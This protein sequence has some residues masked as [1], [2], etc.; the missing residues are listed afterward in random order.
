MKYIVDRYRPDI[1]VVMV[2]END[3]QHLRTSSGDIETEIGTPEFPP[4]YE[5]RVEH[6][7]KIATSAGGHVVWVSMPIIRDEERWPLHERQNAIYEAV[8]DRL[9]NV[10]YVD[11]F[12]RF[13]KDGRYT[14]Y[15]D[16]GKVIQIREDDGLH[17]TADGYTLIMR[18]VAEVAA[19]EFGLDPKTFEG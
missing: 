6:F 5:E 1:T 8:A 7:A 10:A 11:T 19:E 18:L 14:P 16:D 17:F 15:Y 12:D 13:S 9:P 4:A 2:G 3:N